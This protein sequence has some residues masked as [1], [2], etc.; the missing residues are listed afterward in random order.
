MGLSDGA[1][2]REIKMRYYDLAKRTH[3]DVLAV[4]AKEAAAAEASNL[5]AK[6]KNYN[7]GVIDTDHS[8]AP[9]VVPFLEVQAAYDILMDDDA[10]ND[11]AAKRA[12]SKTAG[13][14]TR[15]RTLGEVLCD[16][17]KD[18]PEAF[19]ELWDEVRAQ[20]RRCAVAQWSSC[21]VASSR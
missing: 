8:A 10:N 11:G 20:W 9:T 6:V 5:Q 15:A 14:Q 16:R 21:I 12:R 7:T 18:E 13:T 1:T 4:Q 2:S 19:E 3:P 17:L